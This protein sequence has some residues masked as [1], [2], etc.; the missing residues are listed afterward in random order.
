MATQNKNY[1]KSTYH[2]AQGKEHDAYL[3]N[4]KAYTDAALTTPVANGSVVHTL[5][6]DFYKGAQNQHGVRVQKA[7]PGDNSFNYGNVNYRYFEDKNGVGYADPYKTER[8]PDGSTVTKDGLTYTNSHSQGLIATPNTVAKT[9]G[10]NSGVADSMRANAAAQQ[11][12]IE[13]RRN[14][15][16]AKINAQR[17]AIE[18]EYEKNNRAS[19]NAYLQ[20]INPYGI[21]A[22][23]MASLGLSDSGFAESTLAKMASTYQNAIAENGISRANALLEL[24]LAIDEAYANGDEQIAE[25]YAQMHSQLANYEAQAEKT[26]SE[27]EMQAAKAYNDEQWAQKEFDESNRRY[28]ADM[29]LERETIAGENQKETAKNILAFLNAGLSYAE[30]ARKFG[31]SENV[32]R[33]IVSQYFN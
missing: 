28:E 26:R 23:K 3:Q 9:Y 15:Q 11:K 30:I 27:Y 14:Q 2:D 5:G 13:T 4:G 12:A 29:A 25:A 6:G 17:A 32:L 21:N 7:E 10:K 8:A 1:Y 19:Y 18:Q 22:E 33:N 16:I 31:V 20:S 24:E